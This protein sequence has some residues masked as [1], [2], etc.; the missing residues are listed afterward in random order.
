MKNE[1]YAVIQI[2]FLFGTTMWLAG[3]NKKGRTRRSFVSFIATVW[4][5]SSMA[6]AAAIIVAYPKAIAYSSLGTAL[7]TGIPFCAACW[8]KGNVAELGRKIRSGWCKLNHC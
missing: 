5:M 2:I 7:L 4:A 1:L 6:L 3:F 8:C